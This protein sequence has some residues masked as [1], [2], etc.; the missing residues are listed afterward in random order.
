MGK[1]KILVSKDSLPRCGWCGTY[2][3][4]EWKQMLGEKYCSNECFAASTVETTDEIC[5]ILARSRVVRY[6]T[7]GFSILSLI[8]LFISRH[9]FWAFALFFG[10]MF[11]CCGVC[12]S[13]EEEAARKNVDR[14][15]MYRDSQPMELECSFCSHIN[16]PEVLDCGHCGA[17]LKDSRS[18]SVTIPE[19]FQS[20]S[21]TPRGVCKCPHCSASYLYKLP[22]GEGVVNCHNC[23]KSFS[24]KT[25]SRY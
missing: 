24:P 4:P 19:W 7:G 2:Y 23:G 18:V 14:K 10:S 22:E 17:S 16:P 25:I 12:S 3:S 15:D 21:D 6:L 1:D 9:P 13:T 8:L 5:L 20:G 11:F